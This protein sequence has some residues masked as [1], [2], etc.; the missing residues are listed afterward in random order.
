MR[1]SLSNIEFVNFDFVDD[2]ELPAKRRREIERVAARVQELQLAD[3]IEM[4]NDGAYHGV[5]S[6]M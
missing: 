1:S 4:T 5:D 6:S 2:E 3:E